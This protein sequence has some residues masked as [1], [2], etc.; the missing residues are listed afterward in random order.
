LAAKKRA[1]EA[2]SGARVFCLS[3][4][5][6]GG[7]SDVLDALLALAGRKQPPA[8]PEPGARAWSPL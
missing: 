3:A 7:V 4:A 8:R 1:L 5:T 6:M 2:A